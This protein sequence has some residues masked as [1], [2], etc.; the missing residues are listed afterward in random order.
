MILDYELPQ[1]SGYKLLK[2]LAEKGLLPSVVLVCGQ[3]A[4]GYNEDRLKALAY[5]KIQ[6]IPVIDMDRALREI[7]LAYPEAA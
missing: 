7:L 6:M 5:G 1:I 4:V 2:E 3:D